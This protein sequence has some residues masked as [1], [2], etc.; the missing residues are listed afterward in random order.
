M[1][2]GGAPEGRPRFVLAGRRIRGTIGRRL[3]GLRCLALI[4]PAQAGRVVI[5]GFVGAVRPAQSW[6]RAH[7]VLF[8]D[9]LASPFP[10]NRPRPDCRRGSRSATR[11]T[12][13]V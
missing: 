13:V 8:L 2:G 4:G 1:P 7:E 3:L 6:S 11:R 9:P 5:R 12:S 10:T